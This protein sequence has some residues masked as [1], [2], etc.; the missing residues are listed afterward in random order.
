MVAISQSDFTF[1]NNP[2]GYIAPSGGTDGTTV[3]HSGLANPL[4]GSGLYGRNYIYT[5][6]SPNSTVVATIGAGVDGGVWVGTPATHAISLRATVRLASPAPAPSTARCIGLV[7]KTGEVGTQPAVPRA[8]SGYSLIYGQAYF[9]T[10]DPNWG[11]TLGLVCHD[12]N[13]TN[14][15]GRLDVPIQ[16]LAMDQWHRIRL[17]VIPAGSNDILKVYTGTGLVGSE[18]WTLLHEETILNGATYYSNWGDPTSNKVG[19]VSHA[20]ALDSL[21]KSCYIDD[22]V[23]MREA[24]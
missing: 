6:G 16:V 21:N 4:V 5:T 1:F 2:T 11:N 10:G 8:W 9:G 22:F 20:T 19:Y 13:I 15:N 14:W 12:E 3:L 18:T 24:V 23:A 17:D 7:V